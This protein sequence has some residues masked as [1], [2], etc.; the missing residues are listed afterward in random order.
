[1][2]ILIYSYNYHPE[3]IGI[4][5]LM[6]ELAEGLVSRGHEVRVITGMPNYPQ[7]QI[8][9]E[10]RGKWFCTEERNG[11]I[12]Q[13]STVW[14]RPKPGLMTRMLLD[15]SFVMTSLIQALRGWRPDVILLT[16]PPLPVSISA[17]LLGAIYDCPVVLNLQDILPEA[18]VHVGLIKNKLAIRVFEQ[19]EKFAYRTAHTISVIT[20]GFTE[21]LVGK[22]IHPSKIRCIPNWVDVNFIRPLSQQGND[23][24]RAYGLEDKFVVMY[25]GNIA[26]T[27]GLETVIRTAAQLSYLRDVVFVIVGES[28]ALETLRQTCEKYG[29]KN[30]LLLPFQPREQLPQ[31]L[32]AADVGLVVQKQQ[33]V[34][35]NMPSKI[36]V[37]L[38]S[39]R[40][41]VASVPLT[42]T[43]AKAILQSGGGVVVAPEQP[44][45]LADAIVTLYDDRDRAIA[46]G[47]QGRRYAE[48]HYAFENALSRYESLFS[49]VA[50]APKTGWKFRL[51]ALPLLSP[52]PQPA[53]PAIVQSVQ[54]V[55]LE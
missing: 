34:S 25:S 38:A 52:K 44:D 20:E 24:R 41:I 39:G 1:M 49:E 30:V 15:G 6:T 23:F 55:T 21:N 13:R 37:L 54:S 5:P 45:L 2:R 14:I 4:A 9:P 32:A 36:Q 47:Q 18:A 27:Q 10:Y 8:Y 17:A 35:F 19:L 7:R 29:A 31:M 43:A 12:I 3:P 42:G 46:L 40:P 26:L 22:G 53:T 48:Q 28:R 16:V 50:A 33:V 51:P 11:V